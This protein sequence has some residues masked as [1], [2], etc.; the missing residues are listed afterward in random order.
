MMMINVAMLIALTWCLSVKARL[1]R[2]CGGAAAAVGTTGK[3]SGGMA[4]LLVALVF[5]PRVEA[6][7]YVYTAATTCTYSNNGGTQCCGTHDTI[8]IDA[9]V[10]SIADYAFIDCH[11]VTTVDFSGA[12]ALETIGDRAFWQSKGLTSIDLS[13]ATAL[14]TIDQYAFNSMSNLVSMKLSSSVTSID[15]HAFRY[16]KLDTAAT[17]DFNGVD[18]A[19]ATVRVSTPFEFTCP[20]SNQ[21]YMY[22]STTTC[23]WD[24]NGNTQ[25]C[26]TATTIVIDASVVNIKAFAFRACNTVTTVD[27]SGASGLQTIEHDAFD[28]MALLASVDMSG[29]TQLVSIEDAAFRSCPQLASVK[30]ASSITTIGSNAFDNGI[31]AKDSLD[32]AANVDFN[33]VNCVDASAAAVTAGDSPFEFRCP[34]TLSLATTAPNTLVAG[35]TPTSLVLTL[36]ITTLLTTGDTITCTYNKQVF[37]SNAAST[38]VVNPANSGASATAS[39][40]TGKTITITAGTT[41]STGTTTFTFSTNLA[42][43]PAVGNVSISC[44]STKDSSA[45]VNFNSYTTLNVYTYTS[46]TT[47]VWITVH[48]CGTA[49]IVVIDASATTIKVHAM[50]DCNT[51]TS[52]DFSNAI[53]LETIENNAFY[54]MGSLTSIDFSGATAL[55]SIGIDSFAHSGLL[56]SLKLVSSITSI[57]N[58]AFSWTLLDTAST[59]DFNGVNCATATS[60]AINPFV[61]P[62]PTTALTIGTTVPNTLVAGAMPTTLVLTLGITTQLAAGNTITCTYNKQV[63]L[64]NAAS[65][66]IVNPANSGA[67]ATASGTTGKTITITTGATMSTGTT[68]FTFSTNLAPNPAVSYV[69]IA[70][71]S[72][73]DSS[74]LVVAASYT[75]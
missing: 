64:T 21:M 9:S 65:T 1:R 75:T 49:T 56:T 70:C 53:A 60:G 44:H 27:L 42:P 22:T 43:N 15:R 28:Q 13:G 63:F 57:N 29:A 72:T 46:S 23:A 17:V 74:A 41:M 25:C 62:C 47:C 4:A 69:S 55:T 33:G 48:C 36:G 35:V 73:M 61:F 52:I 2:S 30:L 14:H 20:S 71:H 12:T 24:T 67:S 45:L 50:R 18:C 37:A 6:T 19:A 10:T 68:A 32:T 59:V 39:G 54:H 5:M 40:T 38:L 3:M 26:G 11:S 31:A 8:V 7:T 34:P 51:V 16:T 66:L 58:Y